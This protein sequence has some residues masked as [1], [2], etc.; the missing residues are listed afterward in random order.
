VW[1]DTP[2]TTVKRAIIKPDPPAPINP[3]KIPIKN[4]VSVIIKDAPPQTH[5]HFVSEICQ[6]LL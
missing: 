4:I 3:S 2:K 5:F 6:S 1:I